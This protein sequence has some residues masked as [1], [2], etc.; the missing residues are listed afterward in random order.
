MTAT[1]RT[2]LQQQ[3]GTRRYDSDTMPQHDK[4]SNTAPQHGE[5]NDTALWHGK[6]SDTAA[7][8]WPLVY[9]SINPNVFVGYTAKSFVVTNRV[10]LHIL[11]DYVQFRFNPSPNLNQTNV[12]QNQWFSSGF[13]LDP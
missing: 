1:R 7:C 11:C 9:K 8:Q 4:D 10:A 13:G 3:H 12:N 5:D 6:Y 2:A